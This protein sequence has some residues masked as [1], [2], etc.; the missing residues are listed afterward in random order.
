MVIPGY[1]TNA[2]A[3]AGKSDGSSWAAVDN[4][5]ITNLSKMHIRLYNKAK[6]T[7]DGTHAGNSDGSAGKPA[8]DNV[9]Y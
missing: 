9:K 2:G 4:D 6:D 7:F 5:E 3:A 1:D 8:A